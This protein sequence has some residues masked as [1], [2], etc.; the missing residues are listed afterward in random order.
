MCDKE[1]LCYN[2]QEVGYC[3][4][5]HQRKS[6]DRVYVRFPN[7]KCECCSSSGKPQHFY[8]VHKC[9]ECRLPDDVI[10]EKE[11]KVSFKIKTL[12]ALNEL[13][14]RHKEEFNEICNK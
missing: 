13:I 10:N 8:I 2:E 9:N 7:V 1:A 5:C 12:K 4:I 11:T 14:E 3:E 6:L